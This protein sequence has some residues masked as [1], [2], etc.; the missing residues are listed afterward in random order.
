M[1]AKIL[2][3]LIVPTLLPWLLVED[4]SFPDMYLHMIKD[5]VLFQL[6]LSLRHIKV[7]A[8]LCYMC[9]KMLKNE[10]FPVLLIT[11]DSTKQDLSGIQ[12]VLFP[13]KMVYAS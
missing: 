7:P 12:L 8:V 3:F 9:I 13:L 4:A 6:C 1:S 2:L 5:D 10:F 11:E